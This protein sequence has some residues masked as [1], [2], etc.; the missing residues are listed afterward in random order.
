MSARTLTVTVSGGDKVYD[1]KATA[2]VNLAD[3]RLAGDELAV[4]FTSVLFSDPNAGSGK[5]ITV[6]G[7]S[8]SGEDAGKYVLVSA[9][10]STTGNILRADAATNI[11][12][13]NATYGT[14]FTASGS[15]TG[16]SG[17]QL[18]GL[19]LTSTTHTDAGVYTDS[20]SFTDKTGNYNST[21]GTLTDI[22]N[23]RTAC[24]TY[25]GTYFANTSL[26]AGGSATINLK[27]VVT[28]AGGAPCGDLGTATLAFNLSPSDGVT[29]SNQRQ[30]T[31]QI[32]TTFPADLNI[33]RGTSGLSKTIIVGWELGGNY[34][35][36]ASCGSSST[37]VTVSAMAAE[38]ATGGG[39]IVLTSKSMGSF[40]GDPGSKNIFGF[41]VKLNKSKIGL[42]GNFSAIFKK[43]NQTYQIHSDKPSS[44][45]VKELVPATRNSQAVREANITLSN[46]VVQVLR[47]ESLI[48]SYGNN[49]IVLTIIDKGEP[50]TGDQISFFV[51]DPKGMLLFST[52]EYSQSANSVALQT[53]DCGNIQI[54]PAGKTNAIAA[55]FGV[56]AYPN[57]FT[58]HVYFELQLKT[59][60][61]VLLE[62]FDI[63]GKKLSTLFDDNL[64]AYNQYHLDYAPGNFS[65]GMLIYKLTVDGELAFTGKLIHR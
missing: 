54:R 16:I 43:G 44:F 5:T 27:V 52:N 64:V 11:T 8:L 26:T 56:K 40:S 47:E 9:A 23:P 42:Q 59:D 55:E 21:N 65:G 61:K 50:G 39:C 15:V 32:S 19:D 12:A 3:N 4:S 24:G 13:Y 51:T 46:A 63:Y 28:A 25:L 10:V 49:T 31:D 20:W 29:L 41:N 33:D 36:D 48:S 60:S 38:F 35:A 18:E 37:E 6:S 22:F 1:G 30:L 45:I 17:E 58:G 34:A 62:V 57:P 7:L 2:A 14:A 53:L